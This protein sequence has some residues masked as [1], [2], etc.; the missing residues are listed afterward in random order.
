MKMQDKAK[1]IKAKQAEQI[2]R[3]HANNF[4]HL[5][6]NKHNAEQAN[7]RGRTK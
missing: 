2:N 6:P 7:A 5:F 4:L 3:L 1:G